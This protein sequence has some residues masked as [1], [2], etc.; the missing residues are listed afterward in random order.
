MATTVAVALAVTPDQSAIKKTEKTIVGGLAK[1]FSSVAKSAKKVANNISQGFSFKKTNSE[2][3]QTTAE[4]DELAD[5]TQNA[6]L[7]AKELEDQFSRVSQRAAAFGDVESGARTLGG[8]VGGIGGTI[9]GGAATEE[10]EKVTAAFAEIPAALEAIPR[11]T[12]RVGTLAVR[13]SSMIPVLSTLTPQLGAA[14]AGI[15]GM[16]VS[17]ATM[18]VAAIPFIAVG[19]AIA[20]LFFLFARSSKKAQK[21]A[22]EYREVVEAQAQT[23]AQISQALEAGDVEGATDTLIAKEQELAE[24]RKQSEFLAAQW[25]RADGKRR[26][27]LEKAFNEQGQA[28]KVLEGEV[29]SGSETLKAYG[30]DVANLDR[31]TDEAK[32]AEQELITKREQAQSSID[33]LAAQESKLIADRSQKLATAA[34]DQ[35]IRDARA[36]E[37]AAELASKDADRLA[38]IQA[39]GSDKVSQAAKDGQAELVKIEADGDQARINE[40]DS[41]AKEQAKIQ[42]DF[43]QADL[44]R[45]EKH[46]QA[47]M[48]AEKS[49]EQAEF[50]AILNNNIIAAMQAQRRFET[51]SKTR[52]DEFAKTQAAERADAEKRLQTLRFESQQR[53]DEIVTSTRLEVEASR[54]A[55]R[56]KIANEERA[57]AQSLAN[58]QKAQAEAEKQR[59]KQAKRAAEDQALR[60]KREKEAFERSLKEIQEKKRAEQEALRAINQTLSETAQASINAAGAVAEAMIESVGQLATEV[61]SAVSTALKGDSVTKRASGGRVNAGQTYQVNDAANRRPEFFRPDVSGRIIPLESG[62]AGGRGAGGGQVVFSPTINLSVGDIASPQD[63]V[64]AVRNGL[65]QYAQASINVMSDA[66]NGV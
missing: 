7:T 4:M 22:E 62:I 65:A 33:Q 37:D 51:E 45:I 11:L 48:Q 46:N 29:A 14:V 35:A 38:Q 26:K 9:G 27:E 49:F 16:S 1:A 56:E 60:E 5:S 17:T 10:I 28:I 6:V 8:A 47:K 3:K 34:E 64:A 30:V 31:R 24:A 43:A 20:A 41:F 23:F 57:L 42:A 58:E 61:A 66:I 52:D 13:M 50:D 19:A 53:L 21:A 63:V 40:L 39:D 2:I 54:K 18:V 32:E 55:T 12:Q 59:Q 25:R 15:T 36:A 44:D